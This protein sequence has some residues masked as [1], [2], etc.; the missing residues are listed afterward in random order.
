MSN[1]IWFNPRLCLIGGKWVGPASQS[2]LAMIDPSDGSEICRIARGGAADIDAA[3]QAARTAL[4]GDWGRKT[5][6]ERGRILTRLGQLVLERVDDLM[7]EDHRLCDVII[8]Y[9]RLHRS[10]R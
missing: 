9:C 4:Q 7:V 3:V 2:A 1:P 5:A 10:R 6:L 8:L